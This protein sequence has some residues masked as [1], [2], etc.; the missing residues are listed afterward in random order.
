MVNAFDLNDM[1]L[2]WLQNVAV[3]SGGDFTADGTVNAADLNVLAL[4]W[5]QPAASAA[6]VPE[7]SSLTMILP[8]IAF[9]GRRYRRRKLD[10]C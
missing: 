7:P 9:V 10:C 5:L 1:A 2:N 3:W 8:F 6:M 4:N